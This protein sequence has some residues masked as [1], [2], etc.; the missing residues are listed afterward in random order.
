MKS[1]A[2]HGELTAINAMHSQTQLVNTIL[3]LWVV[4]GVL[5]LRGKGPKKSACVKVP[6]ARTLC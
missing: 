2:E 5:Q 1:T 4:I 6:F 3:Q